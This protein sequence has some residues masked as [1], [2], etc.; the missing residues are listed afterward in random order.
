MRTMR[1]SRSNVGCSTQW[2]RHRRFER[3]VDVAGAVRRE[4]DDR[5]AGSGE[6]TELGDGDLVV[7]QHLEQVRLELVVGA[8]DLVDQQHRRR[9]GLVVDGLQ[10]RPLQQETLVVELVLEGVGAAAASL[11][12]GL[13]GAQVQQLARV[14][15]VVDGLGGIDALVALQADELAARPAAEHL[16]NLGLADARF[17]LE[18]QRAFQRQAPGRWLWRAPRRAGSRA[19]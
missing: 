12:A 5:W 6:H 19:R 4:D 18:Q 8:V 1:T 14:V 15:P 11:A 17:A 2:Y 9:L 3:V 10:Q 13:G 16:G 7:G